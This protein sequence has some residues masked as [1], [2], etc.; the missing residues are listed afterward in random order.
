MKNMR[1]G[2]ENRYYLGSFSGA[3]GIRRVRRGKPG[4]ERWDTW[5]VG[6]SRVGLEGSNSDVA[7]RSDAVK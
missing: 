6:A 1:Q 5:G 4:V 7:M 2:E 3:R